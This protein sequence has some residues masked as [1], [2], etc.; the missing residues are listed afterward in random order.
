MAMTTWGR[1]LSR[2]NFPII[3]YTVMTGSQAPKQGF[4]GAQ[5]LNEFQISNYESSLTSTSWYQREMLV[6]I[7]GFG[8]LST[9]F[10]YNDAACHVS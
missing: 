1:I 3:D 2:F 10:V 7:D 9:I 8:P 6:R 5:R 4:A